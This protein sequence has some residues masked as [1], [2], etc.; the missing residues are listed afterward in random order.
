MGLEEKRLLKKVLEE[1]LPQTKAEIKEICGAEIAVE[2]E[3]DSFMKDQ[4]AAGALEYLKMYGM[5]VTVEALKLVCKDD[6]GKD[7][8]KGGLK[9]IVFKQLPN[10]KQNDLRAYM[11]DGVVTIEA[12]WGAGYVTSS[13]IQG[14]IEG[15]L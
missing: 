13:Q 10:E 9:R 3:Q 15:G 1:Q 2:I 4:Y 14:V 12:H 6:M 11:K 8:V 5:D 7:A